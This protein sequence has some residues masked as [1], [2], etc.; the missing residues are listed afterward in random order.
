MHNHYMDDLGLKRLRIL[1]EV[2]HH[3]G[4]T[5][6]GEAMHYSPSGISQ[7]LSALEADIGA[8]VLERRGRGVRLT[9]VGGVLLEHAEI[10]LAS[11][12]AARA[13]VEQARDSLA[14][15]LTVGVF[16]TAA[17]SLFPLMIQDLAHRHPEVVLRAR[18]INPDDAD[19]DL[20]H[21]HLDLAFLLDYPDAPEPWRAGITLVPVGMDEVYLAAPTGWFAPGQVDLADLAAYQWVLPGSRNYY[22]RAMRHACQLAGLEP[23]VVYEVDE[24]PTALA[25]VA[26]GLGLTLMSDLGRPFL[27][28]AGVDVLDLKQTVRRQL[29]LG[30][31]QSAHRRPAISAFLASARRTALA[32]GLGRPQS[33]PSS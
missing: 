26:A 12:R 3:G 28:D 11:E 30:Y 17:A 8:K 32:S 13:A 21:G 6:A 10:V 31:D 5:A 1:R 18:E 9:Q 2:A 22:G 23:R 15:E 29:L 16:C 20:R 19:R 27:P 7:Q 14:V 25:M 24:Q 33:G 4:V